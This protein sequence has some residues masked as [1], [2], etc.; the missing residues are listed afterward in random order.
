MRNKDEAKEQLILDTAL[1]LITQIGLTGL[2]MSTLAKTA[3][4]ATG[5][6]YIYFDDK[7]ALIQA[8]YT[9]LVRRGLRDLTRGVTDTEPLRVKLKKV[10]RNYLDDNIKHPEHG[11]FFEQYM[12][13]P[14]YIETETE[15]MLTE[16]KRL[17]EP[18]YELVSQGQRE[19]I[20][21][22]ADPDL[23][24]TLVCGMLNELAKQ[25]YFSGQALRE[26]DWETTFAII[27]DG[28]KQ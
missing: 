7:S 15:A 6:I 5:T 3:G 17:M 26:S 10:A 20:I 9:H 11:A 16:E 23:L 19:T 13:S 25:V 4:L 14:Y 22:E 21:K 12:R 27:W 18:I 1:G 8:L 28:I 24:V 2:T